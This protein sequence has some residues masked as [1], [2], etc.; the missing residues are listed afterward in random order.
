MRTFGTL[1]RQFRVAAALSQEALAERC[2][3]SPDTIAALERGR[4][5]A[6]RLST[7]RAIADALQLAPADRVLFAEA[8]GNAGDSASEDEGSPAE[9][10]AIGAGPVTRRPAGTN[11]QRPGGRLPTPLTPLFGRQAESDA[12]AHALASQ[13]LVTLVG[14]GG[15]GKTRL[16]LL[17]ANNVLDNFA[18]GTWW[19]ELGSV[20]DP[21]KVPEAVLSAL[22][23]SEQPGASI[24]EQALASLTE[25]PVLF[26]FDNCEHVLEATASLVSELLAHASLT[27]LATSREPLGIPG[28]IRWP[29]PALAVPD[30]GAPVAE[31]VDIDSVQLFVERAT[32]AYPLFVLTDA[33]AGAAARICRRLEGIPLAIEL[34]AARANVQALGELA[35]ELEERIPLTAATARGV[36]ARQS[37]LLACVDWSYRLL[38]EEERTALRCLAGFPGS[39]S[40]QAFSAVMRRVASSSPR[41]AEPT[42]SQLTAKSLVFADPQR[43]RYRA[44]ETI[45]VFAADRADEASELEAVYD[46]HAE[47]VS[48]WLAELGATNASDDVLHEIETEYANI[49]AALVRSIERRSPHAAAIVADLG[50]AWHQ[51]NRFHDARASSAMAPSPLPPRPTVPAGRVPSARSARLAS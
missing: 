29:V 37:T 32:R 41:A 38:D 45:R 22:G 31:L 23:A 28:E 43:G 48:V 4:R 25:E 16:A 35:A 19:I 3:I 12:V 27:V 49:R 1:L 36:P 24:G 44:L 50:V 33:N 40:S 5:L 20:G 15:V 9:D 26:V 46:A 10:T 51:Q 21:E 13:R 42:L 14:P 17:L 18:G 2:R 30:R 11:K 8:A 34:A 6:P 7:V 39:F 47:W